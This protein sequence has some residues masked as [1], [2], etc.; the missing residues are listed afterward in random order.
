MFVQKLQIYRG[1]FQ[2]LSKS[3]RDKSVLTCQKFVLVIKYEIPMC[4]K[5]C[6]FLNCVKNPPGWRKIPPLWNSIELLL[7]LLT[8]VQISFAQ[9]KQEFTRMPKFS[10]IFPTHPSFSNEDEIRGIVPLL[11]IPIGFKSF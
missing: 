1:Q 9:G 3:F 7:L 11:A 6:S 4:E 8:V 2:T 10:D 5:M